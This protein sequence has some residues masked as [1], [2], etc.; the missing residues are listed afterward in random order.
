MMM[1]IFSWEKKK[2]ITVS[3]E[4]PLRL[5]LGIYLNKHLIRKQKM[6][7]LLLSFYFLRLF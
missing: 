2:K 7:I 3:I 4:F 6:K 1:T 5:C